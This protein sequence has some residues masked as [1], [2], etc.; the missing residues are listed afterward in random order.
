LLA[1]VALQAW[2][3]DSGI[4]DGPGATFGVVESAD[5]PSAKFIVDRSVALDVDGR[6]ADDSDPSVRQRDQQPIPTG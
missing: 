6:P 3:T 1:G 2:K 5:N 4:E